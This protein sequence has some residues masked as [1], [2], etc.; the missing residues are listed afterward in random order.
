MVIFPMFSNAKRRDVFMRETN[1]HTVATPTFH[2]RSLNNSHISL[3]EAA[4]LAVMTTQDI[5]A[6]GT[7]AGR[8]T[9]LSEGKSRRESCYEIVCEVTLAGILLKRFQHL[10]SLD[11][12]SFLTCQIVVS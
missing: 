6:E 11:G 12:V 1:F 3:Y 7:C 8:K 10:Y 5:E 4:R 2:R 9:K